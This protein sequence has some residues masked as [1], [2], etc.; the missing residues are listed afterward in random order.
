MRHA[1]TANSL[2]PAVARPDA[3]RPDAVGPH[4]TDPATGQA[5]RL[6][7]TGPDEA[8]AAARGSLLGQA[9]EVHLSAACCFLELAELRLKE[10]GGMP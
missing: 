6:N 2:W 8:S 1:L 3:A 7:E 5:R 4:G 9:L 10:L